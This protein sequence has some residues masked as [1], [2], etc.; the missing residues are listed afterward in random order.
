MSSRG[1]ATSSRLDD[2]LGG[3]EGTT[4][5]GYFREGGVEILIDEDTVRPGATV[6]A[7]IIVPT[8]DRYVLFDI[9]GDD[10]MSRQLVRTTGNVKLVELKLGD[11]HIPNVFLTA[12]MV[13]DL[14]LHQDTKEIIV[15]PVQ[16][17]LS[18]DVKP[19]REEYLPRQDGTLT[20]TARDADGK[21][22]RAEVSLGVADESVYAIQEDYAGDPRPFFYGRNARRWCSRQQLHAEAYVKLVE[23]KEGFS[24]T[25]VCR[26]KDQSWREGRRVGPQ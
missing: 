10:I 25:N 17:F 11:E 18:V 20:I 2:R 21:P 14:Q 16:K 9:A 5:I 19:D 15:P 23:V 6:P 22:V 7:M 24:S 3:D 1:R 4:R 12:S 8:S 13:M 26:L